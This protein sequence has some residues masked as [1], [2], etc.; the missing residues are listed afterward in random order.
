MP[1]LRPDGH[2]ALLPRQPPEV[3]ELRRH[4]ALPRAHPERAVRHAQ[5]PCRQAHVARQRRLS[6]QAASLF[7]LREAIVIMDRDHRNRHGRTE[8]T[9]SICTGLVFS[10]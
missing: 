10:V 3:L 9:M 4:L 2:D 1:G 8:D 5:R 7:V 6:G